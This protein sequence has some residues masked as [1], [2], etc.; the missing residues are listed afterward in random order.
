MTV[1]VGGW[2]GWGVGTSVIAL[3][4][5]VFWPDAAVNACVRS[6]ALTPLLRR[7][8]CRAHTVVADES[9]VVAEPNV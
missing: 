1:S 6:E 8:V 2:M 4:V 5:A 7:S 9:S 3:S